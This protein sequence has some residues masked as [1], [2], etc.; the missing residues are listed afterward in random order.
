MSR[1]N[2]KQIERM[3]ALCVDGKRFWAN[4][5][6]R[7]DIENPYF[8]CQVKNPKKLPLSVLTELVEEMWVAGAPAGK[9][10]MVLV[11]WS[12]GGGRDTPLLVVLP[13]T[14]WMLLWTHF[15]RRP[16]GSPFWDRIRKTIRVTPRMRRRVEKRL[17]RLVEQERQGRQRRRR[18]SS[19]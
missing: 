12:A 14:A 11:K 10:P 5:G 13:Q 1:T 18:R 16:L 4:A 15:L 8:A 9:L 17:A 3:A 7:Q 6:E 19:R 2:W